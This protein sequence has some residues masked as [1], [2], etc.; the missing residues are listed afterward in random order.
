[1]K[2]YK[3]FYWRTVF[4]LSWWYQFTIRWSITIDK[5]FLERI[6]IMTID[7]KN[8]DERLKFDVNREAA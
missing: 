5:I 6:S 1:M 7:K 8:K 2:V 3:K 4:F